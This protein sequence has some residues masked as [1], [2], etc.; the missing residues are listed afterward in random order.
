MEF[1]ISES[2]LKTILLEQPKESFREAAC[3]SFSEASSNKFCK[4]VYDYLVI[5][6]TENKDNRRIWSG[7]YDKLSRAQ[8]LIAQEKREEYKVIY[9]NIKEFGG[10]YRD[11][12]RDLNRLIKNVSPSCVKLID[13][14]NQR[15]QDLDRDGEK[16][17]LY[18]KQ[19]EDG[20]ILD[21]SLLN[22]LNTNTSGLTI[23][24]TEYGIHKEP[25]KTPEE[26]VDLFLN[27]RS[28]SLNELVEF[29]RD[30]MIKPNHIRRRILGTIEKIKN[31][32]DKN[33]DE[34][35]AYLDSKNKD[36]IS[37]KDDFG[38]VD[39]MGVDA[40]VKKE[41]QYYPIQIKTSERGASGRL[42]IWDYQE[43]GCDC[44]VA[45]KKSGAWKV[46]DKPIG[47]PKKQES[48]DIIKTVNKKGTYQINCE[49]FRPYSPNNGKNFYYYCN[50]SRVDEFQ[51]IPKNAKQ[52]EFLVKN[53]VMYTADLSKTIINVQ[54]NSVKELPYGGHVQTLFFKFS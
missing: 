16:M 25:N 24:M 41:N 48:L 44:F 5:K 40:L 2:Q 49:S 31:A 10:I 3:K 22:R 29:L 37:F 46:I 13:R 32:G 8:S 28:P 39:M 15:I 14:T 18:K 43:G 19:T 52:I 53:K 23:L 50:N 20:E 35:L 26:I 42:K 11:K 9:A 17:L 4:S 7:L 47:V 30:V 54:K 45:Y 6:S 38:F 51:K 1:L 12:I 21:Y 34:F 36:Y 33:E 27:Y